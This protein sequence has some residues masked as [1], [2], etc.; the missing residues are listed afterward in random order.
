M[1]KQV[2][3]LIDKSVERVFQSWFIDSDKRRKLIVA[4]FDYLSRI[5]G[6]IKNN[7][8]KRECSVV[9]LMKL[10]GLDYSMVYKNGKRMSYYTLEEAVHDSLTYFIFDLKERNLL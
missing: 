3:N 9:E 6:I 10:V 8:D 4:T 7:P 1:D 5:Y 2:E